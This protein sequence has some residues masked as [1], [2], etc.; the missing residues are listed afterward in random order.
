M[1]IF[2]C[3]NH[4]IAS[5][6]TKNQFLSPNHFSGT[7]QWLSTD[8][9]FIDIQRNNWILVLQYTLSSSFQRKKN[10]T[11]CIGRMTHAL[12][13]QIVSH[14]WTALLKPINRGHI[15]LMDI[16]SKCEA[17]HFDSLNDVNSEMYAGNRIS[18]SKLNLR[19]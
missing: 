5:K 9:Y 16:A 19:W 13:A 6:L 14:K 15:L 17:F 10:V 1:R 8:W 11:Y 4:I 12:T 7:E 3:G 2:S 18:C